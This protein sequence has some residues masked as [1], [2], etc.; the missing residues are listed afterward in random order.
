M[1]GIRE[2][3][4]TIFTV[5]GAI[6]IGLG[7]VMSGFGLLAP[8]DPPPSLNE[9]HAMAF[10]F[11]VVVAFTGLCV[12]AIGKAIAPGTVNIRARSV[13][14]EPAVAVNERLPGP[15]EDR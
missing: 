13:A 1:R 10:V 3:A 6:V 5:I 12:V 8:T 2:T 15:H 9:G 11:G 4:S 14:A 7:V